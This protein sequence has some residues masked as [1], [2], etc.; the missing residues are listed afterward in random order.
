MM[1][2]VTKKIVLTTKMVD[3]NVKASMENNTKD[4]WKI[5]WMGWGNWGAKE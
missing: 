1:I 2:R 4:S 3:Y 5:I